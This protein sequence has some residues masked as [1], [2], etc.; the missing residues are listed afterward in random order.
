MFY[1][2]SGLWLLWLLLSVCSFHPANLSGNGVVAYSV[3]WLF[4]NN[5]SFNVSCLE[6]CL[7]LLWIC[8][9]IVRLQALGLAL[10]ESPPEGCPFF[11]LSTLYGLRV[12]T[13]PVE[14]NGGGNLQRKPLN[15][16]IVGSQVLL[17]PP[18][19]SL[20]VSGF[21]AWAWILCF[22]SL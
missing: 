19:V 10:V 7:R 2:T 21:G 15:D 3:S 16:D 8:G 12:Y 4:S 11:D 17:V 5:C 6:S 9:E 1:G 13:V 14:C 20:F 18:V 22:D